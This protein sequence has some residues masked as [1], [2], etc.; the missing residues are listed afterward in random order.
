M[1]YSHLRANLAM[2]LDDVSEDRE[3]TVITRADHEP[4]VLLSLADYESL[5]ET[6]Y[7]LQNPVNA[8]R[9]LESVENLEAGSATACEL[10]E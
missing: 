4:V 9:L 10:L 8:R 1:S 5:K 3:E 2:A 7:L 6:A